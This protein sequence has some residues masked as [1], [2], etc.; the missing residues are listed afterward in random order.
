MDEGAG[1]GRRRKAEEELFLSETDVVVVVVVV[2]ATHP[3]Q[4]RHV[5]GGTVVSVVEILLP[6]WYAMTHGSR[7]SPHPPLSEGS[8]LVQ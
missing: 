6:N 5:E 2:V 7:T 8:S 3:P 1:R 4:E